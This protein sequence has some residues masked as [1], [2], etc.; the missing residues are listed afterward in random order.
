MK[1]DGKEIAD[2]IIQLLKTRV[3]ILLQKGVTPHIYIITF[4]QNPNTESYLKQK[5]LKAEQIGVKITIERF[6]ENVSSQTILDM[7]NKLNNDQSVNG[8]IVQRPMPINF[9]EEEFSNAI[10]KEKDIDGFRND[11]VFEV[12]V[13]EAVF[14]LLKHAGIENFE[15]KNVVLVGKGTTA[16]KPITDLFTKKGIKFSLVDSKTENENEIFKNADIIVS[17]VGRKILNKENIKPGVILIGVGMHMDDGKL[18]GDYED[19]EVESIASFYTPTPG[20]VG[21]VNVTMLMKNLVEAAENQTM[22]H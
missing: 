4:G 9:S 5:L 21:P 18:K 2:N 15:A 17:S 20:G 13:A 7:I 10:I 16:G 22:Q 14:E 19:E 3:N 11:S 12:P 1:I 6:E 8:I